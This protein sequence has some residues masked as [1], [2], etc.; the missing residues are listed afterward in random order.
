MLFNTRYTSCIYTVRRA[1][2]Y[3]L[4][5]SLSLTC[6][7]QKETMVVNQGPTRLHCTRLVCVLCGACGFWPSPSSSFL[8]PHRLCDLPSS[9]NIFDARTSTLLISVSASTRT[10]TRFR[11]RAYTYS[12]SFTFER[13][14]TKKKS[15]FALLLV[16]HV[17]RHVLKLFSNS[18]DLFYLDVLYVEF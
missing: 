9:A 8:S 13:G 5:L 10:H 7:Y 12:V 3:P 4:S 16:A 17:L 15:I 11:A 18:K 1:H 2:E 14:K 6:S